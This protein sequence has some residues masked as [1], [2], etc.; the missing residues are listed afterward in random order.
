MGRIMLL[1]DYDFTRHFISHLINNT[2]NS[3]QP[4]PITEDSIPEAIQQTYIERT[5]RTQNLIENFIIYK[6]QYSMIMLDGHSACYH[7]FISAFDNFWH[8]VKGEYFF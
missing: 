7:E 2:I 1:S 6:G 5:H 4:N 3:V 8:A